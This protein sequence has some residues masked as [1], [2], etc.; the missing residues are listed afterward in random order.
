M[1]RWSVTP[2]VSASELREPGHLLDQIGHVDRAALQLPGPRVLQQVLQKMVEPPD[3]VPHQDQRFQ[4]TRLLRRCEPTDA[5]LQ[6]RQ[7]ERRRVQG[8]ADLVREPRGQR[9]HCRH[10][11]GL[12]VLAV[13]VEHDR[14][15][16]VENPAQGGPA[17]LHF[18]RLEARG[19]VHDLL[20]FPPQHVHRREHVVL[21]QPDPDAP[22]RSGSGARSTPRPGDRGRALPS[23][24]PASPEV[25]DLAHPAPAP[26]GRWGWR[27]SGRRRPRR[28]GESAARRE[29]EAHAA[30]P[31]RRTRIPPTASVPRRWRASVHPG[32]GFPLP[33]NALAS[34]HCRSA[35]HGAC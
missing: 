32:V 16:E 20:Q 29:R 12:E 8:V 1:L 7:L 13:G 35:G 30:P 22:G 28:S 31:R 3:L 19:G 15:L 9:P 2:R 23:S 5:T 33:S 24:A 27:G 11:L 4:G 17:P 21:G 10:P 34:V 25:A 6:H 14:Q 26:V 18:V